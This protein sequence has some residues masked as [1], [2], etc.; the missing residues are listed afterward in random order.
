MKFSK[1][2][3][4]TRNIVEIYNG[5][6][7]FRPLQAPLYAKCGNTNSSPLRGRSELE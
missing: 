5:T 1:Q 3:R 6:D 2:Q 4:E 7:P